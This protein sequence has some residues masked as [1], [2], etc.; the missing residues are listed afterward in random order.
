MSG[1]KKS[2][3]HRYTTQLQNT[4]H[5]QLEKFVQEI[6]K[7]LSATPQFWMEPS[8][9]D[10]KS[11]GSLRNAMKNIGRFVER[12]SGRRHEKIM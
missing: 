12:K 6:Q 7:D 5:T 1:S 8:S 4:G 2:Y 11:S 9:L 10:R 3:S